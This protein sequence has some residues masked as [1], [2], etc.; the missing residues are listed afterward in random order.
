MSTAIQFKAF[1]ASTILTL[2]AVGGTVAFV[3]ANPLP[4]RQSEVVAVDRAVV[5]GKRA[6]TASA[7]AGAVARRRSALI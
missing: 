6:D 1:V 5:A 7:P 3:M 2:T 4:P